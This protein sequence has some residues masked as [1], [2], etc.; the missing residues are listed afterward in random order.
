MSV[1]VSVVVCLIC[2]DPKKQQHKTGRQRR[3]GNK[4]NKDKAHGKK[5]NINRKLNILNLLISIFVF[6]TGL[7]LFTQFHIG[8]GAHREEW[9]GLGKKLWLIIHQASA[10]GFL[11]GL[12]AHLQ[13]HWKYIKIVAKQWRIS[14]PKKI[15]SRTREQIL[16]SIATLVVVWAGSYPWIVM[17][18]NLGG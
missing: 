2:G 15:K 6:G 12:A 4:R 11:V 13:M 17:P 8:D 16:L 7:I 9:R 1:F 18:G 10:I 3:S 5:I 14:L